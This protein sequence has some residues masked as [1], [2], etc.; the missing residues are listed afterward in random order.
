MQRVRGPIHVARAVPYAH[1]CLLMAPFVPAPLHVGSTTA[2]LCCGARGKNECPYFKSR[3]GDWGPTRRFKGQMSKYFFFGSWKIARSSLAATVS[4]GIC[5]G[6][7]ALGPSLPL[8]CL[9]LRT[10]RHL[11]CTGIRADRFP[12]RG[13]LVHNWPTRPENPSITVRGDATQ[14]QNGGAPE[15]CQ[16][17]QCIRHPLRLLGD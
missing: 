4:E 2:A 10:C 16:C 1:P 8:V 11:G 7:I 3:R 5:R 6:G 14:K 12:E 13:G 17:Q 9:L 15:D